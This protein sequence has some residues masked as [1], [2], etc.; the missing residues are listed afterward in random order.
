MVECFEC[1]KDLGKTRN[2]VCA[3]CAEAFSICVRC[4]DPTPNPMTD[5]NDK[6]CLN[7]ANEG[8]DAYL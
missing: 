1:D 3:S 2:K 4:M 5:G 7:C 6:I 8:C